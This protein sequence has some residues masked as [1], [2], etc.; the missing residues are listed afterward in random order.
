MLRYEPLLYSL[1]MFPL[2]EDTMAHSVSELEMAAR[3]VVEGKVRVERQRMLVAELARTGHPVALAE[4]LLALFEL[5]VRQMV[6]HQELMMA[7]DRL[8]SG[9]GIASA[10]TAFAE[11]VADKT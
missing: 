8:P 2:P 5:T 6:R 7:E 3:Q 9:P 10:E 11:E 4:R 1:R